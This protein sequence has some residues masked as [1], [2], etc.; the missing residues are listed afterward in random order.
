MTVSIT[1]R[2]LFQHRGRYFQSRVQFRRVHQLHL[3]LV[4]VGVDVVRPPARDGLDVD[5]GVLLTADPVVRGGLGERDRD[6]HGPY[7]AEF[8][9]VVR[10]LL[11]DYGERCVADVEGLGLAVVVGDEG[12][13][14]VADPSGSV[15]GRPDCDRGDGLARWIHGAGG[16]PRPQM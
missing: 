13:A 16:L 15:P 9:F 12:G 3:R 14:L 7:G 11:Q 10:V 4:L 5:S 1:K 6:D 8:G 2:G